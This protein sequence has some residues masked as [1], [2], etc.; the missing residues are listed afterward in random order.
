[1]DELF[2]YYIFIQHQ[3]RIRTV[4][5]HIPYKLHHNIH[6]LNIELNKSKKSLDRKIRVI[7]LDFRPSFVLYSELHG[8]LLLDL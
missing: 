6:L 3:Q 8:K 7:C 5:H 1:M 4:L 2:A